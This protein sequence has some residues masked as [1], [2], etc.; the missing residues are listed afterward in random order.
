M[1]E[2]SKASLGFHFNTSSFTLKEIELLSSILLE[3]LYLINIINLH[4][5]GHRY[6]YLVNL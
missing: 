1:N 4:K 6:V 2:G 3:K 5:N